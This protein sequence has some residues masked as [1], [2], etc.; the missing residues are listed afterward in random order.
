MAFP[1]TITASGII[2]PGTTS[3]PGPF[4]VG[5]NIYVFPFDSSIPCVVCFKSTD[6]GNTWSQVGGNSDPIEP[7][8]LS[9]SLVVGTIIYTVC[10]KPGAGVTRNIQIIAFDTGSDT[11]S[12]AVDT[13]RTQGIGGLSNA[14]LA[15]AYRASD[16][17]IIVCNLKTS[18][19]PTQAFYFVFDIGTLTAGPQIAVGTVDGDN[20]DC[21]TIVPGNGF[22]HF[23]LISYNGSNAAIHT[24]SLSDGGA[25][26]TVDTIDTTAVA[27]TPAYIAGGN[28]TNLAFG[29]SPSTSG[30]NP[31]FKVF[32]GASAANPVLVEHDVTYTGFMV[33]GQNGASLSLGS[34][35]VI[36]VFIIGSFGFSD[37]GYFENSGSGFGAFISQGDNDYLIPYANPLTS[38][39]WGE[40]VYGNAGLFFFAGVAAPVTATLTLVKTVSPGGQ[41]VAADFIL[42]ATGPAT[43]SG[44]G[45]VGPSSVPPGTYVLSETVVAEYKMRPWSL[46]GGGTLVG[47][48]LT[49]V[50]GDVAI[51]TIVND[52]VIKATAGGGTYFPR[53]VNKSLLLAQILR[54]PTYRP[55]APLS[56]LYDFPNDN[57]LCLSREWRLYNQIDPIALSCA[58]KP[59]CFTGENASRPWVEAP[60]GAVTFNPDKA[61]ALPDPATVDAVVLSFRVPIAYDGI[62]L[63]QYHAYRGSGVFVEGSGDIIW[64][65]RV[66]G[67]YLRDMGNMQ[68]SI[69]SPQTLS[70]VPG[71]LFV[72][73]GNLVE[74]VVSAPNGSGNLPLPGQGFILSGLHGWF[75]PRV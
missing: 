15:A 33:S 3:Y 67:R 52:P 50:A 7:N 72:H 32:S 39:A 30:F 10:V 48:L 2:F 36:R 11:F 65:V 1:S 22:T 44:T 24:Q 59:D 49:L 34:D 19:A 29:W 70:P 18:A 61:I 43:I 69:G 26:S 13:S 62:I 68:V 64:R 57:D 75:W 58:R 4:E 45:G 8:S 54:G 23:F 21:R 12:A 9:T 20:W 35:N 55:F 40:L 51:A 46:A 47:N 28:G 71:G 31:V 25:L 5:G 38:F 41:A 66:N 27:S 6:G 42:S 53:F 37:D 60:S 73:S 63:A 14:Y 16:N 56:W 74:Y 17:S